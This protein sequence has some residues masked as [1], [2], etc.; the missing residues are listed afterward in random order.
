VINTRM[1]PISRVLCLLMGLTIAAGL[2]VALPTTANA[3]GPPVRGTSGC[4]SGK[5][6]LGGGAQV[7]G[8]GSADFRTLI[9]ETGPGTIN[10]GAQSLWLASVANAD[11]VPHTIGISAVCAPRPAGY[12]VVRSDRTV[13]A[14]AFLRTSVACPAGTVVLGG[15]SSVVGEGSADFKI[16]TQESAP[17]TIGGGTQSV[18]LTALRNNDVKTHTVGL[19]ALCVTKPAGYQ[20]VTK[21]T[22]V[23]AN[24]FLRTTVSCPGGKVVA[25][26]GPSVVGEGSA[27]FRTRMQ[28]SSPGTI[29]APAQS[30]WLAAVRNT[31][32]RAHTVSVSAVCLTP[33]PGYQ[34]IKKTFTAP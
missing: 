10:G 29:G 16:S 25:G 22:T 14:R 18:W 3:A 27:D 21:N 20:V 28:E 15:G 7:T 2:A 31:D 23:A 17:G 5:V 8:Q 32:G 34:V 1:S 4:P 13:A 19:F 33:Q 30:L 11:A 12:R 24:G 26:G 6:V 9:Q